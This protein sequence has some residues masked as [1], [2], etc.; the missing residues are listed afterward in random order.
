MILHITAYQ[1]ITPPSK[2]QRSKLMVRK[3][4]LKNCYFLKFLKLNLTQNEWMS[5]RIHKGKYR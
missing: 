3:A 4:Q 1:Y 2:E 5:L